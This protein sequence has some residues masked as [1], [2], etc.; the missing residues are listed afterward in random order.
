M[1][2]LAAE[3][4]EFDDNLRLDGVSGLAANL[5]EELERIAELVQ[6]AGAITPDV[7]EPMRA[8]LSTIRERTALALRRRATRIRRGHRNP[9][10]FQYQ[11][12]GHH[13]QQAGHG[14]H[15]AHRHTPTHD[16]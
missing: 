2:A 10:Q 6:V 3:G 16:K 15:R 13:Q 12:R 9:Q 7:V 4:S 11:R 1:I 14:I 5:S 8:H